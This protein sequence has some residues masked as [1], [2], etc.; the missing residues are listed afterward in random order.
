MTKTM[1]DHPK[2]LAKNKVK[3]AM[4]NR[5][6]GSGAASSTRPHAD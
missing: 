6:K 4:K 5:G 2:K 1:A 3:K